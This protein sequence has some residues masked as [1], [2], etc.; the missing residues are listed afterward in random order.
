MTYSAAAF[1]GLT[2]GFLVL[3]LS[4]LFLKVASGTPE[5]ALAVLVGIS[6]LTFLLGLVRA[7]QALLAG[8]RYRRAPKETDRRSPPPRLTED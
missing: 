4:S 8:I 1:P 3:A 7:S 5:V 6:G 2:V